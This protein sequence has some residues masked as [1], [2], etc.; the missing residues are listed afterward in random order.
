MFVVVFVVALFVNPVVAVVFMRVLPKSTF[1][2]SHRHAAQRTAVGP[3]QSYKE[4]F[5]QTP[6]H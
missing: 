4:V 1:V 5:A 6:V 2:A 3:K